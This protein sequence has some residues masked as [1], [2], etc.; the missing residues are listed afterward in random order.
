MDL[1]DAI[2]YNAGD[3]KPEGDVGKEDTNVPLEDI[4]EVRKLAADQE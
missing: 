2:E 1:A 3:P 4:L